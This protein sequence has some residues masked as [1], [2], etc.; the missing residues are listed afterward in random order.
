MPKTYSCRLSDEE[1]ELIETIVE[2][3]ELTRAGLLRGGLWFYLNEDP[4]GVLELLR[5]GPHA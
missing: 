4:D 1:S 5:S 2:E 3:T